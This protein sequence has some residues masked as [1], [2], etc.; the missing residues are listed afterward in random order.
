MKKP[1][2]KV[3]PNCHKKFYPATS[4][5]KFCT[6]RCYIDWQ[7]NNAKTNG[8]PSVYKTCPICG[9]KFYAKVSNQKY[10]SSECYKNGQIKIYKMKESQKKEHGFT[11]NEKNVKLAKIWDNK[12]P[13]C[14]ETI[15]FIRTIKP[16]DFTEENNR[17]IEDIKKQVKE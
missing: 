3:C 17:I 9:K 8:D 4:T 2:A 6:R 15:A 11:Q 5:Q 13:E 14:I 12:D 16:L 10:C 1:K 7:I